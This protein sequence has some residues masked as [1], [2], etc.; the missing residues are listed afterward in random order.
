MVD[1]GGESTAGAAGVAGVVDVVH[2]AVLDR[3]ERTGPGLESMTALCALDP[4]S[5][6]GF[7][8]VRYLQGWDAARCWVEAQGLPAMVAV[9]GEHGVDGDDWVREEVAAACNLSG[10]AAQTRIEIARA[11][12]S[13]LAPAA[14]ALERGAM[15]W[16]H[17]R[18]L[19][20][21]TADLT[22]EQAHM[23]AARSCP[24]LATRR[25]GGGPG[26]SVGPC[27]RSPRPR[28]KPRTPGR[29]R[30]AGSSSG[31]CPTGWPGSMPNYPPPTL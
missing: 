29:E 13:R 15:T 9:A 6:D 8:R 10:A 18:T 19:V 5:L 11:C 24:V 12:V 30:T 3:V 20:V 16:L 17:L 31:S 4:M 14:Q 22:D 25:S 23:V 28:W 1:L 21:E 26:R 2:S 7:D 27:T